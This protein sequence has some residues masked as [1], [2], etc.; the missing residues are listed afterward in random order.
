MATSTA[1]TAGAERQPTD[2]RSSD[3]QAETKTAWDRTADHGSTIA[4]PDA[5]EQAL[6]TSS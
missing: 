2:Q 5:E 4:G 6:S 3:D 1:A